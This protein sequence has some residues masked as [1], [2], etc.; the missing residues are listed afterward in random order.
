MKV[1][2][3]KSIV[4]DEEISELLLLGGHARFIT[5]RANDDR[6]TSEPLFHH[7]RLIAAL[8]P[9]GIGYNHTAARPSITTRQNYRAEPSITQALCNRHDE[10]SLARSSQSEL[11]D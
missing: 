3:L 5:I 10:R 7:Q 8:S 6:N 11:P 4:E 9:I 2:V 1:P